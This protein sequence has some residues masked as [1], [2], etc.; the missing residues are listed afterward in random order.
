MTDD[1]TVDARG[2][3][4]SFRSWECGPYCVLCGQCKAC[5]ERGEQIDDGC[6]D[7]PTIARGPHTWSTKRGS[8]MSVD[9]DSSRAIR[10]A[11]Q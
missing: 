3:G 6:W 7:H 9:E 2:Y 5:T 11:M 8:D 10:E 1:A 4:P